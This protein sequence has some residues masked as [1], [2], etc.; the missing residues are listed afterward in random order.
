[1]WYCRRFAGNTVDTIREVLISTSGAVKGHYPV[2]SPCS[3][4]ILEVLRRHAYEE[5][6]VSV[7][8]AISR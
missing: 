5:M 1:M 8:V 6:V 3:T 2:N 4:A 7:T